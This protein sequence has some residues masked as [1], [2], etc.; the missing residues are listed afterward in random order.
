MRGFWL[1][2]SDGSGGYCQGYDKTDAIKIAEKITGKTAADAKSLPYPGS[3]VIWQ[4]DHPVYGP[5]PAFC[6]SPKECAGR[7][8][9]PRRYSC[10]E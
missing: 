7:T 9:C 2:F 5:T 8:S 3:P 4:I 10:V 1:T 6:I